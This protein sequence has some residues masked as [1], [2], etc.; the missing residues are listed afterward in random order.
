MAL[1]VHRKD[2]VPA[3][4]RGG[5]SRDT[6]TKEAAL[7]CSKCLNQMGADALE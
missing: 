6:W 5:S 4:D 3:V 1:I 7:R 2:I